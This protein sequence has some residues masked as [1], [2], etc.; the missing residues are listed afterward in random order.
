MELK[1][2]LKAELNNSSSDSE[3]ESDSDTNTSSS[4]SSNQDIF[5][6][7]RKTFKQKLES[8]EIL[9]SKLSEC[10]SSE[11][12]KKI[13]TCLT[14]PK[15]RM[16]LYLCKRVYSGKVSK[17]S[18]RHMTF[19]QTKK[20]ELEQSLSDLNVS[21]LKRAETLKILTN[22]SNENNGKLK[23][24]IMYYNNHCI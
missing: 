6:N 22:I 9:F 7:K 15:L 20:K 14:L 1:N 12:Q 16:I 13:L 10:K 8:E 2:D 23:K 18:K 3:T 17:I 19:F 11:N 5:K 24:K 21:K 4:E